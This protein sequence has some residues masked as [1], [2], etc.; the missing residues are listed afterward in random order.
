MFIGAAKENVA[1]SDL[2]VADKQGVLG[3]RGEAARLKASWP[4]LTRVRPSKV[5]EEDAL[6]RSVGESDGVLKW[7]DIVRFTGVTGIDVSWTAC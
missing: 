2:V 4:F 6:E 1:T 7:D 5:E 3:V